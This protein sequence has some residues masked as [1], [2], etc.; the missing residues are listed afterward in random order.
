MDAITP[1]SRQIQRALRYARWAELDLPF[2]EGPSRCWLD[3]SS[4]RLDYHPDGMDPNAVGQ[5]Q[6]PVTPSLQS[7]KAV[8]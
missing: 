3:R 8:T 7:E 5:I 2:K 1:S 6:A 4:G